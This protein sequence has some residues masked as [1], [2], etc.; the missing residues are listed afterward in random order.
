VSTA[1]LGASSILTPASGA[2]VAA[3]DLDE[4]AA[5]V[6]RVLRDESLRQQMAAQSRRHAQNWSSISM[7]R[8]LAALY[9]DIRA[10]SCAQA[11]ASGDSARGLK[12]RI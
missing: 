4:F 5:A 8:R 10:H 11:S 3:E 6:L 1:E 12:T 9:R 2:L 7:A